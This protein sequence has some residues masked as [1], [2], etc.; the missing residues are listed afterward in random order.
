[1]SV[2]GGAAVLPV[3]SRNGDGLGSPSTTNI[4]TR[5]Y[6]FFVT[7]DLMVEVLIKWTPV[8]LLMFVG[9]DFIFVVADYRRG[10]WEILRG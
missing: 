10:W 5:V 1:M 8:G 7:Y 4:N 3:V 2:L 6:H 9:G